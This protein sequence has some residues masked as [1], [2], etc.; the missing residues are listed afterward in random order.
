MDNIILKPLQRNVNVQAMW[1]SL[2]HTLIMAADIVAPL[3]E[4]NQSSKPK[5]NDTPPNI[6]R[7]FN[8]RKNLL[9]IEKCKKRWT[10]HD[11]N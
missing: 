11:R 3:V 1:N 4:I 9:R 7:M 8:R 6:K 5:K 2:E 10:P